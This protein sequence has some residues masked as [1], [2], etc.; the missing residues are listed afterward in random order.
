MLCRCRDGREQPSR[1]HY[2]D[3]GR[4]L[5]TP[6][7]RRP[8][9]AFLLLFP[10]PPRGGSASLVPSTDI[11]RPFQQLLHPFSLLRSLWWS[12]HL[13]SF[14]TTAR[15]I[16]TRG[17]CCWHL[18]VCVDDYWHLAGVR[19]TT[20]FC[21]LFFTLSLSSFQMVMNLK[22]TF[23]VLGEIWCWSVSSQTV[24]MF[25][26]NFPICDGFFFRAA[27]RNIRAA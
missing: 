25:R 15:G 23:G 2:T 7:P 22:P 17:D 19:T 3:G 5:T 21:C 18:P 14:R 4:R 20:L 6:G 26:F 11:Y 27:R 24:E 10:C 8:P 16:G 13:L 9:P 1:Q 12:R